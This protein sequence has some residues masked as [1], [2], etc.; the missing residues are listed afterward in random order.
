MIGVAGAGTMGAGIAQ[1]AC[2]A[3]ARTLLHDPDPDAL[4]RGIARIARS[5]SAAWSVARWT[6]EEAEQAQAGS[7]RPRRSRI[8]PRASW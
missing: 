3:G 4:E 1:L 5:S 8:S 6:P 2:L 7:S